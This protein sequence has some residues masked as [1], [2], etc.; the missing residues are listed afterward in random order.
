[1]NKAL[2]ASFVSVVISASVAV[3]I[4]AS[5]AENRRQMCEMNTLLTQ[6]EVLHFERDG[7]QSA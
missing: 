6:A 2:T 4:S 5:A 7:K 1:M 3:G